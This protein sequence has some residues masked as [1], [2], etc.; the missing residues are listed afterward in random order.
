MA[1][2]GAGAGHGAPQV[3]MPPQ[4]SSS[5][6][7]PPSLQ[8]VFGIQEQV[9]FMHMSCGVVQFP[10]D[11]CPPQPSAWKPQV[12]PSSQAA[13]GTQTHVLFEQANGSCVALFTSRH[14]PF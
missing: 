11:T 6:P 5:A 12:K 2:A 7:Q 14:V 8:M 9:L 10:Q 1:G 3:R 13:L 4:P